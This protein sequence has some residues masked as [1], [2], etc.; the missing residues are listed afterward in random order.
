MM[1]KYQMIKKAL[2]ISLASLI[3]LIFS[4][5]LLLIAGLLLL[6]EGRPI[7]Y[8]SYRHIKPEKTIRT[9][10]F[11]SMVRDATHPRHRLQERFMQNGYLDIPLSCEVYTPIGRFLERTQLVELLQLINVIFDGMSLV[12]NRPLPKANLEAMSHYPDWQKRFDSPCGLTGI[13]QVVGK[14]NLQP[15]SRLELEKLYAENYQKANIVKCDFLIIFYTIRL[16]VFQ[17]ALPLEKAKALLT[18]NLPPA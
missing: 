18:N 9:Y 12:G 1:Q 4:P 13:T 2:D 7:F 16:L 15:E 17:K 6:L 3:L 14:F 11:R 10:K 5:L 8:I